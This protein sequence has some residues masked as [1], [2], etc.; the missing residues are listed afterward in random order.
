MAKAPSPLVQTGIIRPHHLAPSP[1]MDSPRHPEASP[2]PL[3]WI[4]YLARKTP[5]APSQRRRVHEHD[6]LLH[7]FG[8]ARLKIKEVVT[9]AKSAHNVHVQC[10]KESSLKLIQ[11]GDIASLFNDVFCKL[12]T[13]LASRE[14]DLTAWGDAVRELETEIATLTA[15]SADDAARHRFV[16]E[17]LCGARAATLSTAASLFEARTSHAAQAAA[18]AFLEHEI[19]RLEADRAKICRE[20]D[21]A[22]ANTITLQQARES[23]AAAG[24]EQLRAALE[25]AKSDVE[26]AA[27]RIQALQAEGARGQD[28]L[29]RLGEVVHSRDVEINEFRQILDAKTAAGA[30]QLV[31]MRNLENALAA[32]D[33]RVGELAELLDHAQIQM[34]GIQATGEVR[35]KELMEEVE[36]RERERD[37]FHEETAARA[38]AEGFGGRG[39]EGG[40]RAARRG[41]LDPEQK[42]ASMNELLARSEADRMKFMEELEDSRLLQLQ[43]QNEAAS[44]REEIDTLNAAATHADTEIMRL[45]G[46]LEVSANDVTS[47]QEFAADPRAELTASTDMLTTSQNRVAALAMNE[48]MKKREVDQLVE[49]SAALAKT[50]E[51]LQ[52]ASAARETE[53]ATV[54]EHLAD[55]ELLLADRERTIQHLHETEKAS[56]NDREALSFKLGRVRASYEKEL[57]A[58]RKTIDIVQ[59]E[60]SERGAHMVDAQEATVV[61]ESVARGGEG[62]RARGARRSDLP[63]PRQ[64]GSAGEAAF[65]GGIGRAE[66]RV[67][68]VGGGA[69]DVR[70]GERAEVRVG[71]AENVVE[72]VRST[73]RMGIAKMARAATEF[74]SDDLPDFISRQFPQRQQPPPRPDPPPIPVGSVSRTEAPPMPPRVPT[75]RERGM[76]ARQGVDGGQFAT[77]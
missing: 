76:G 29:A 16:E 32:S 40:R 10:Q 6:G 27:N 21:V 59:S 25:A 66:E 70:R 12:T 69:V 17:E 72:V 51:T 11:V 5:D 24:A 49:R 50:V 62:R 3:A 38:A 23:E 28:A 33:A 43:E 45:K 34:M 36:T 31:Q 15:S 54:R 20:R 9:D 22:L 64:C 48:E 26:A 42:K 47:L 73:R 53:L 77:G 8:A 14:A 2:G 65:W 37:A 30:H 67:G 56:T 44:R 1:A 74:E 13:D 58:L 19:E 60:A 39:I 75:D 71:E 4:K 68:D 57:D 18:L 35:E 61:A 52:T 41:C 55:A 7:E 63:E 46:M